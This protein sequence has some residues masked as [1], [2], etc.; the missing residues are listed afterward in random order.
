MDLDFDPAK[1]RNSIL[2]VIGR[3]RQADPLVDVLFEGQAA[4][5]PAFKGKIAYLGVHGDMMIAHQHALDT[6]CRSYLEQIS[7]RERTWKGMYERQARASDQLKKYFE[8]AL[9]ELRQIRAEAAVAEAQ[10]ERRFRSQNLLLKAGLAVALLAFAT[11]V[12]VALV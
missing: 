1:A 5:D 2:Q 7:E 11:V 6:Q 8:V 12:V 10:K 3:G 4:N 9:L